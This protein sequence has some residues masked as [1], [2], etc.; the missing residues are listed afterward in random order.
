MA[1][2]QVNFGSASDGSQGD[3]ARAAF[4]KINQNFSDTTN[5]ASR[6]VGT[7]NG[8]VMEVGAFGFGKNA[9]WRSTS[10]G[11]AAATPTDVVGFGI[12]NGLAEGGPNGLAIPGLTGTS[13]GCLTYDVQW[14][15]TSAL[16]AITRQFKIG[17]RIFISSGASATTW[18]D[19]KEL[20]NTAN[21]TVSGVLGVIS[22]TGNAG[23]RLGRQNGTASTPY[24]DVVS[25]GN[26]IGYDFRTIWKGGSPSNTTSG[27]GQMSLLGVVAIGTESQ[28]NSDR[29]TVSGSLSASGP[30]R[31]GQY[32]LAS[33]PSASAFSGYEID[34]TDAAG[35]AKRCRSDGTNWKIINTTTTVS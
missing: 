25:G 8:Q 34:V 13:Y 12:R 6:L 21:P 11:K 29:L 22:A 4:G 7:A 28:N 9:D 33:L 10:F 18:T 23:L 14:Q 2:Q 5:A 31:V 17:D 35:G 19:W 26:N 1:L 27:T 32:T 20:V 16:P 3:T 15:D 30:V 24:F